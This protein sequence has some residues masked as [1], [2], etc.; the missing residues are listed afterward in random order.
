MIIPVILAGGSGT[1]LWP[2]SRDLNP[3]QLLKL[4]GNH[5][6]LQQTV[7]RVAEFEG[8]N[9]P[10]VICN[11]K[12]KYMVAQQ[13]RDIRVRNNGIFLEPMGRNTAP[14]VAIAALKGLAMSL[15]SLILILPADHLIKNVARFHEALKVG[16]D[17]ARD[18]NL[19]TFGIVPDRPETGYGYIK[20]GRGV[21]V[22]DCG[23]EDDGICVFA[24]D[25][26][27]EKPDLETAKQYV[28]SGQ[29]CWNSGMFMFRSA[30]VLEEMRQLVPDIVTVC[31]EA[32]YKGKMEQGFF[33]LN[34]EFFGNCPSD[35]I[36]YAVMEKTERGV[37][38]PLDAGWDDV[39][40]WEAMW[41]ISDK[42][43]DGN[44]MCGDVIGFD[45]KNSLIRG[46]DRLV[47]AVGV[48]DL[49][50]VETGD[51]VLVTSL[52]N[53]QG[54]KKIVDALKASK[55]KET[56]THK[57]QDQP[58]GSIE[59][60]DCGNAFHVRRITVNPGVTFSI[61]GHPYASVRWVHLDGSATLVTGTESRRFDA[62]DSIR[63][64]SRSNVR[65]ENK[66]QE[67]FVFLEVLPGP[68]KE[69][70]HFTGE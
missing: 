18:G 52:S 31:E 34:K 24:I 50:I 69:K 5:T 65:L 70:D 26:F 60:V 13:L 20:K 28:G 6:M 43:A 37:M 58:W 57:S 48:S 8:M 9:L 30:S 35:S 33:Y 55:R 21:P 11:E 39:G 68:P 59:P 19:V 47:T 62:N 27:V 45:V 17:F 12:Q 67:T 2:L 41:N 16:V 3:K 29:Y 32:F 25:Q 1:R 53:S 56:L 4:T 44:V 49:V 61:S 66:G 22:A 38:I 40:S 54:V 42:D 15:E 36:D 14:A 23:S 7:L 51:A 64:E 63:I 10:L 46:Q